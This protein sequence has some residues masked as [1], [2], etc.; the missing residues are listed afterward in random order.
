MSCG[1]HGIEGRRGPAEWGGW[2]GTPAGRPLNHAALHHLSPLSLLLTCCI[3]CHTWGVFSP[4][5]AFSL[6]C[7]EVGVP[8]LPDVIV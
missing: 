5:W 7:H 6:A 8:P 3:Q 1:H 4:T 2:K